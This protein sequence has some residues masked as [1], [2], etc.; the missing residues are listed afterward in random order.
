MP[1]SLICPRCSKSVSIPESSAGSR[2]SCPHCDQAFLAP[3]LS[4]TTADDADD[5]LTLDSD[6]L[7]TLKPATPLAAASNP[8]PAAIS[9]AEEALLAEFTSELDEFT[10]AI[11]SVPKPQV[12]AKSNRVTPG[13]LPNLSKLPAGTPASAAKASDSLDGVIEL[14]SESIVGDEFDPGAELGPKKTPVEYAT[15]YR[16]TCM[17]CGSQRMAHAK[18]A[19]KSITCNDCHS[20]IRVPSP[21]RVAKKVVIDMDNAPTFAFGAS[22]VGAA[23]R[24]DDP[25]RKSA[26][27]LLEEASRV[28]QTTYKHDDD[29]PKI[30][31]WLASIFGIFLDVG[32]LAHWVGL[33]LFASV[34]AIVALT[35]GARVL[36]IA[37]VPAGIVFGA[38]VTSC[39]YAILQ[40]VAN[41]ETKVSE[42][43]VVDPFGW[44]E[45][46][47][48]VFSA[49]GFA[50]IPVYGIAQL[51]FGQSL[52]TV[53]LTMLSLYTLFPFVLLSMLDMNSALSPFS[54]EVARSVNRAQ[55]AWGGLYFT[56]AIMFFGLFLMYTIAS[57]LPVAVAAV[58]GIF[59]TVAMAFV[60]FAMIGRLAYAIGQEISEPSKGNTDDNE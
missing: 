52:I 41:G 21:P 7:P 34:P 32:V 56:A 37:L 23:G 35:S 53:A 20:P 4:A 33:S 60:Y 28:Q 10:S 9:P 15:E 6:P 38:V 27:Q 45:N 42:W 13:G 57:S 30:S 8:V 18:Q 40:S 17:T 44:L 54:A 5:W 59:L 3:G 39:G 11:E 2:I 22:Q 29:I 14:G 31:E 25:Y 16:V 26:Q 50:I 12:T 19:G 46:L 47:V 24:R 51:I 58:A 1:L 49:A 55:E 36:E 43:P 48:V